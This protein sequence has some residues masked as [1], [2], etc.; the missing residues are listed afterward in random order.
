MSRPKPRRNTRQRQV[1][2][3]EL[4]KLKSHP[5]A[6]DLH[7]IVRRRLP[8]ISLGTVYRNLEVLTETG[9]VQ[10][11]DLGTGQ[12]RFDADTEHHDHVRCLRCGR[13]DDVPGE[14]LVLSSIAAEDID[15]FEIIGHR[16]EYL[17]VCPD[18]RSAA[19]PDCRS[20]EEL[21]NR[22]G[23]RGPAEFDQP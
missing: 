17:G 5:T 4:G 11:L 14:P 19:D 13:V 15:G 10:K 1:I 21:P 18:C 9:Q 23:D 12:A 6:V 7:E 3:E 22:P 2:L 20:A 8:R 16:V